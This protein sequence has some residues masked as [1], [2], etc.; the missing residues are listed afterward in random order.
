MDSLPPGEEKD[1]AV[2]QAH[3][4]ME[5]LREVQMQ[6]G[7]KMPAQDGGQPAQGGDQAAQPG[8]NA[9]QPGNAQN[10]PGGNSA[11]ATPSVSPGQT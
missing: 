3:K 10:Q 8:D 4:D 6:P 2:E 7:G 11:A 1:K 9:G 5:K